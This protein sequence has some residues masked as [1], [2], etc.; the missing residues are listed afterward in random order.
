MPPPPDA[1]VRSWVHTEIMRG[2]EVDPA[3]RHP[4]MEALLD[5]L[6]G[7]LDDP[8]ATRRRRRQLRMALLGGLAAGG[9]GLAFW[10]LDAP[11]ARDAGAQTPPEPVAAA[12]RDPGPKAPTQPAAPT[13]APAQT[14]AVDDSAPA[15][16]PP[17]PD[18]LAVAERQ[19]V[20]SDKPGTTEVAADETAAEGRDDKK[21]TTKK[22]RPAA[23]NA[24]DG[25]CYYRE[26]NRKFIKRT[27]KAQAY[28]QDGKG[29]CWDCS[30]R[31]W[32]EAAGGLNP[33][34]CD[35]Y[36]MCLKADAASCID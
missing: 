10:G 18:T 1:K 20:P 14:N 27:R 6:E 36:Y 30:H 22:K 8:S 21:K 28:V 9:I 24:G 23:R 7:A 17:E 25:V 26:H 15:P 31:A 32:S 12:P 35:A 4:G 13:P 2:L 19:P 5:R 11:Q 33:N 29:T 3:A 16:T 34:D